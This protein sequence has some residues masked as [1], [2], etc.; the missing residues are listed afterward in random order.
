MGRGRACR[1]SLYRR[2]DGAVEGS[3]VIRWM[4][5]NPFSCGTRCNEL[6]IGYGRRADRD[7]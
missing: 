4:H 5:G 3:H 1:R 6:L 2:Y 7:L